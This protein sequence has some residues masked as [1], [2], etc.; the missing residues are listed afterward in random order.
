MRLEKITSAIAKLLPPIL[1]AAFILHLSGAGMPAFIFTLLLPGFLLANTV[2]KASFTERICLALPFSLAITVLADCLSVLGAP[3]GRQAILISYLFINVFLLVMFGG[4][5]MRDFY[6]HFKESDAKNT[7]A[8][9]LLAALI[10]VIWLPSLN[11]VAV[12]TGHGIV[13]YTNVE[14]VLDSIIQ[15]GKTPGWSMTQGFG[16]PLKVFDPPLFHHAVAFT[17]L[18]FGSESLV[19]VLNSSTYLLILLLGL[20]LASIAKRAGLDNLSAILLPTLFLTSNFFIHHIGVNGYLKMLF[21]FTVFASLMLL[22]QI[23]GGSETYLMQSSLFYSVLLLAYPGFFL[24]AIIYLAGDAVFSWRKNL[25]KLL[26]GPDMSSYRAPTLLFLSITLYFLIP[27][28]HFSG[29]ASRSTP[30]TPQEFTGYISAEHLSVIFSPSRS[31]QQ[32]P[33][34]ITLFAAAAFIAGYF[35][36]PKILLSA[37]PHYLSILMLVAVSWLLMTTSKG[38]NMV[39][40]RIANTCILYS[41]LYTGLLGLNAVSKGS[42]KTRRITAAILILLI[43]FQAHSAY[44]KSRASYQEGIVSGLSYAKEIA[45]LKEQ[46][47]AGLK[48]FGIYRMAADSYLTRKSGKTSP[49]TPFFQ[50]D[51]THLG[52]KTDM[53]D[54]GKTY[55][56]NLYHLVN[57]N[58]ILANTCNEHG[59]QSMEK[60]SRLNLTLAYENDCNKIYEIRY[61]S[62]PGFAEKTRAFHSSLPA[63]EILGFRDA[64]KAAVSRSPDV[65]QPLPRFIDLRPLPEPRPLQVL[66]DSPERIKIGGPFRE[67][68]WV[69]V[70]Q[71][72]FPTWHAYMQSGELDVYP[73]VLGSTLIRTGEGGVIWMVNQPFTYQRLL[74]AFAVLGLL[75]GFIKVHKKFYVMEK[76]EKKRRVQKTREIFPHLSQ[77]LKNRRYPWQKKKREDDGAGGQEKAG[78]KSE[79]AGKVRE[80]KKEAETK[81]DRPNVRSSAE[82]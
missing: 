77:P 50:S 41:L 4:R 39:F 35:K 49:T 76:R 70:K 29:Y 6:S 75:A 78:G 17:Y 63:G 43:G 14:E 58:Y 44:G 10:T 79:E 5:A 7:L 30:L 16:R 56:Q 65:G 73:T 12:P 18:A 13:Y 81:N 62:K 34:Q 15:Q 31:F 27:H 3:L 67:G 25:K 22:R 53:L 1:F 48:T 20:I 61:P 21:G 55:I 45:Y 26:A 68:E 38:S 69:H 19:G 11:N 36:K 59:G 40:D 42:R 60:L 8:Y 47:Y 51:Y 82:K 71:R 33:L 23:R 37:G 72:Y 64:Y 24:A 57:V 80:K 46:P 9:L 54:A 66:V 28:T 52:E 32:Y 74:H 2:K